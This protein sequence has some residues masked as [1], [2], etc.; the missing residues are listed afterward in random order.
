VLFS[1]AGDTAVGF[2]RSLLTFLALGLVGASSLLRMHPEYGIF[3]R[4]IL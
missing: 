2:R 1:K 4:I 3:V